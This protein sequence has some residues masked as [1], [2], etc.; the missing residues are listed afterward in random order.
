MHLVFALPVIIQPQVAEN[1]VMINLGVGAGTSSLEFEYYWLAM[2]HD[3]LR[4]SV[5]KN[6]C[7]LCNICTPSISMFCDSK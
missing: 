2:F 1:E 4:L 5:L 6:G 7:L 3:V